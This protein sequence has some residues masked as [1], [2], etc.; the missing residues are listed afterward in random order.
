MKNKAFLESNY[1]KDN[2]KFLFEEIEKEHNEKLPLL[3]KNV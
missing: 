3:F 1:S 2:F